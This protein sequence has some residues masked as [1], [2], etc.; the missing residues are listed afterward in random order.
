MEGKQG[1]RRVRIEEWKGIRREGRRRKK[2]GRRWKGREE[3]QT[4]G[5]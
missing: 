5:G 4:E 1:R 3:R 2:G